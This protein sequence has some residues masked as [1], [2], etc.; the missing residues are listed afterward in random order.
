MR[1]RQAPRLGVQR[2]A[3]AACP[4]HG[5]ARHEA[6]PGDHRESAGETVAGVV[7]AVCWYSISIVIAAPGG[8]LASEVVNTL[9]RS[10]STRLARWPCCRART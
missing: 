9:G 10:C 8:M 3:R 7:V 1:E 4:D 5:L 2:L 6:G